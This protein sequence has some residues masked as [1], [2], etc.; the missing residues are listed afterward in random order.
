M[1]IV[2]CVAVVIF[3]VLEKYP[4]RPKLSLPLVTTIPHISISPQMVMDATNHLRSVSDLSV[5]TRKDDLCQLGNHILTI[6]K[7]HWQIDNLASSSQDFSKLYPLYSNLSMQAANINLNEPV[8]INSWLNNESVKKEILSPD[9]NSICVVTD[10]SYTVQILGNINPPVTKFVLYPTPRPSITADSGPWGISKQV[11]EHTWTMKVG[12][13]A[14]MATP[15]EIFAALNIYR[16]RY[17]SSAL[18]WDQKLADYAQ[19]RAVF[20]NQI[21]NTDDHKGFTD[22]LSNEDGFNKLGFTS[23]GEN[24]FYGYRLSGVHIIEWVYAG[25]DS[26]NKNQLDNRWNYV[27]IGVSGLGNSIIFGTGKS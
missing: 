26:H 5:L 21:K 18:T 8:L 17:G 25:D 6:L 4:N 1:I 13:D 20:L 3:F 24:M 23:L 27:G 14:I 10:G 12:Q 2:C 11:D 15:A 7:I 16:R 9:Y 22:F 19:S